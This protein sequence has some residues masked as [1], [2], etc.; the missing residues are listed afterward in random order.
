MAIK[1]NMYKKLESELNPSHL[2]IIDDSEKHR[3]HAGYKEGGG[4]H[5]TI[6]I[7]S[8]NFNSKSK[9]AIHKMIY[10]ILDEELKTRVHALAIKAN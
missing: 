4:T 6:H 7:K 9:V 3:G 2:E 1:E 5:F 10:K 8:D